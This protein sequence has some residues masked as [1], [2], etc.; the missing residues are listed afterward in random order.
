M[1]G[2]GVGVGL[3]GMAVLRGMGGMG[4]RRVDEGDREVRDWDE[5]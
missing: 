5:K 1:M 3:G 4:G 2:M